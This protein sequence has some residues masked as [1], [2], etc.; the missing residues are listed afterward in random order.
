MKSV[1]LLSSN[2]PSVIDRSNLSPSREALFIFIIYSGDD[3]K[4]LENR[5]QN[6]F[7][8]QASYNW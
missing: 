5:R 6:R 3:P 4:D 7:S 8:E 2:L 1:G